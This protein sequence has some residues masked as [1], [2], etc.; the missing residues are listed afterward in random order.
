MD[1]QP[2]SITAQIRKLQSH[3]ENGE[4]AD[5]FNRL[6]NLMHDGAEPLPYPESIRLEGLLSLSGIFLSAINRFELH[7]EI[8]R[9]VDI[10]MLNRLDSKLIWKDCTAYFYRLAEALFDAKSDRRANQEESIVTQIELYI[11]DHLADDLSLTRIGETFGHHPYYLSRLYKQITDRVLSDYITEVRLAKAK[12]LLEESD[13]R[14]Q[15]VSRAIGILSEN[16]FYRF[17]KK[18]TGTTPQEYRDAARK[19]K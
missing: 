16:Y 9:S 5:F 18:L 2:Q 12:E 19:F 7:H 10:S 14:I 15:D 6:A 17:F 11:D 1:V 4:R 3:L 13:C 8:S